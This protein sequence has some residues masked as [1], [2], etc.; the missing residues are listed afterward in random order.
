M[1][2]PRT[3]RTP[4][5][6][7]QTR[8]GVRRAA[9]EL[10]STGEPQGTEPQEQPE[11]EGRTHPVLVEHPVADVRYQ[12]LLVEVPEYPTVQGVPRTPHANRLDTT[13]IRGGRME[14]STGASPG[15]GERSTGSSTSCHPSLFSA[16][17]KAPCGS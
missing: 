13:G 2:L 11:C 4:E 14:G 16:L 17:T 1:L 5:I 9:Q 10:L 7:V 15:Q 12:L 6:V 8:C 3:T